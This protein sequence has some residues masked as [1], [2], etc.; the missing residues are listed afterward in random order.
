[1]REYARRLLP[2]ED[3]RRRKRPFYV[4]LERFLREPRFVEMV[5][6]ALDAR[7]VRERGYF[8]PAAVTRLRDRLRGGEF[9]YAKQV[10][11]LL[12]LELWHRI[13]V[14]RRATP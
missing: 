3:A 2:P 8:R 11:S 12:S 9:I 7:V 5:D 1:L 14:D 6:D 10:F 13:M 4:P